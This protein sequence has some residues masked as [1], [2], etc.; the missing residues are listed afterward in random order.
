MN[1]E[2]SPTTIAKS[3]I[4]K[5]TTRTE[6]TIYDL[7]YSSEIHTPLTNEVYDKILAICL[8]DNLFFPLK[9]TGNKISFMINDYRIYGVLYILAER[10][11][12]VLDYAS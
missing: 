3:K 12:I 10:F 1:V 5:L 7:T 11:Y 4:R 9:R 8:S 2:L 6:K